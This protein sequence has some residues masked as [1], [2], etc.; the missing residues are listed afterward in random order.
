MV[1]QIHTILTSQL[2]PEEVD[3]AAKK[4]DKDS[5]L[6]WKNGLG[7]KYSSV[8]G[9]HSVRWYPEWSKK[10]DYYLSLIENWLKETDDADNS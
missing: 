2:D 10:P 7:D 1:K 6:T 8:I 3:K 5:F 9:S 4:F